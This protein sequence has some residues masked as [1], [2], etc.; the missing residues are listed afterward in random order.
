MSKRHHLESPNESSLKEV[1]QL[2]DRSELSTLYPKVGKRW[3][4]DLVDPI[5]RDRRRDHAH[6]T[7]SFGIR[8]E[9]WR[10]GILAPLPLVLFSIFI[11]FIFAVTTIDNVPQLA[12]PM[13]LLFFL[14][15]IVSWFIFRKVIDIFYSYGVRAASFLIALVALL[16]L[17]VQTI[18]L[19][20][21]PLH[22]NFLMRSTLVVAGFSLALSVLL[23]FGLLRLWTTPRLS[24]KAK[25]GIVAILALV[26]LVLAALL[27]VLALI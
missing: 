4:G 22:H 11:A 8:K 25:V 13:M 7:V 20:T 27:T 18:H 12:I 6:D 2:E 1:E 21:E 19:I 23:S 10:V 5:E 16:A 24:G 26:L 17:S 14:W 9:F 15:A 3:E